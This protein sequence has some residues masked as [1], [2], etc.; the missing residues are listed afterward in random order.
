MPDEE[1]SHRL[2]RRSSQS[3]MT[4]RHRGLPMAPVRTG[5]VRKTRSLPTVHTGLPPH[6]NAAP[7][8]R[9]ELTL[10][11]HP[12]QNVLCCATLPSASSWVC[13]QSQA[14]LAVR[15]SPVNPA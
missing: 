14:V 7:A 12:D 9:T 4:V 11:G 5:Q 15:L 8:P 1:L 13:V 3:C 6:W 10:K 2:E